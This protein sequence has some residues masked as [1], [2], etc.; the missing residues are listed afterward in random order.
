[1]A[2]F[3]IPKSAKIREIRLRDFLGVDFTTEISD[4]N[5]KRSPD[6]INMINI[7]GYLQK[8][9]GY[10]S[11]FSINAPING[12]WNIDTSNGEVIIIHAGT[13][14]YQVS[15]DFSQYTQIKTGLTNAISSGMVFKGKLIILDGNRAII[16]GNFAGSMQAKYL[17][18]IGYIPTTRIGMDPSTGGGTS[19]EDVNMIQAYRI[20]TFIGNSTDTVYQLDSTNIDNATITVESLNQNGEWQVLTQN[21]DYTV[22]RTKGRITFTSAKPTPVEGRDNISVRFSKGS[23]EY[24]NQINKCTMITTFG[25]GGNNN[26]IFLAGNPAYPNV[27]WRSE[28]DDPTYFPDT[29]VTSIGLDTSPIKS[30]C[31][32]NDG[33]LGILKNVSDTD[34][35]IYYRQSAMFNGKESFPL[36]AGTKGIGCIASRATA[37]VQNE[38]FMLSSQG[39]FSIVSTSNG[40]ERYSVLRSYYANGK[41]LKESNLDK[42]VGIE[43]EG[44]YYLAINNHVYICDTRYRSIEKDSRT[45]GYQY[46][47]YY[48]TNIPVRLWFVWNEKLYF[49]TSEGKICTFKTNSDQNPY[50]DISTNVEAYWKT[51]LLYF[52]D[53]VN[54]KTIKRISV[55]SNPKVDSEVE[56]LYILKNG[57]KNI[58]SKSYGITGNPFP[59]IM[60]IKRKAKKFMFAQLELRS[61]N[62]VNMSF[63][64]IAVQYIIGGK[65]RGE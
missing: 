65:Y 14:L 59:K 46:E 37:T 44:K 18:E 56:V 50:Q 38:P 61:K 26:R 60:Q 19:Y 39:V 57:E 23:T 40:D 58:V 48:L 31:R 1:M 6:A 27:D 41:L 43:F 22:N 17:D 24:L 64:E 16:Y 8:R 2:Q 30:Y 15:S 55:A 51:P 12:I 4:V 42:A 47:W 21:T 29:A 62:P 28:I 13:K 3:D 5:L 10:K 11:I 54:S 49:A 20:N 33:R 34:C 63:I 7:D 25:Y 9:F 32:L 53:L 45:S 36:V 35:T 52:D